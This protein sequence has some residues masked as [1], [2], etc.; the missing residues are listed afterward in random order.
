MN[1]GVIGTVLE[2]V[3]GVRFD[4]LMGE[5]FFDPLGLPGG[6]NV[7][8]LSEG[9]Q[10]MVATLYRKRDREDVWHPDGE[11]V[12]Q[13]DDLSSGI[14]T[15]LPDDAAYVPGNN[16]AQFSPQG[17]ARLSLKGLETL[18][19]L[20]LGDGSV[21]EIQMLSPE[22]MAEL[23]REVWR[24]DSEK[25]N[26]DDSDGT[27]NAWA[28]GIRIITSE[29]TGDRLFAGDDREWYGHFGEAYGLLAGVWAHP[30][31]GDAVIYAITGSAF[32]PSADEGPTSTLAP[33]EAQILAQLGSL[34]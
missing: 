4:V 11:W 6:F 10:Q 30:E 20:F 9:D 7:A 32:N 26:L 14:P 29:T 2:K 33:V 3:T 18:A 15:A 8:D 5:R 19:M 23:R 31:S 22:G 21:G 25:Q 1:Y 27:L 13:V 34:L 28:A 16:G 24:Y 17:G 12:A